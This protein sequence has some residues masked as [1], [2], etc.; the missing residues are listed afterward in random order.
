MTKMPSDC[1]APRSG[2]LDFGALYER[3]LGYVWANL[4]RLGIPSRDLPDVTHDVFVVVFRNLSRYDE[5]RPL[6][7]WLFGVLARVGS[8]HLRLARNRLERLDEA[9]EP[10]DARPTPEAEAGL[11]EQWRLVDRALASLPLH[12]RVVLVMHDIAGHSAREVSAELGIPFKTVYS[13]LHTARLRVLMS[14]QQ[15]K[16]LSEGRGADRAP[17]PEPRARRRDP[18]PGSG[19]TE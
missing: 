9:A 2:P 10:W 6:R 19:R 15:V 1:Q 14:A 12:H 13:R 17:A 4:R 7:P 8:D 11:R 16:V 18:D 3:E 5:A